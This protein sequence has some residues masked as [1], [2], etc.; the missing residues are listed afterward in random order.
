MPKAFELLAKHGTMT[1]EMRL[2][3]NESI[4]TNPSPTGLRAAMLYGL[5]ASY[6]LQFKLSLCVEKSSRV[7]GAG[8]DIVIRRRLGF[9]APC[10]GDNSRDAA[11]HGQQCWGIQW[12]PVIT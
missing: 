10:Q 3:T 11:G 2:Q 7:T 8:L 6:E 4:S 1:C 5:E 12:I 9:S